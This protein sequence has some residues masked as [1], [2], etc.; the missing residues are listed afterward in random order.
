MRQ[1]E[2]ALYDYLF[3][4]RSDSLVLTGGCTLCCEQGLGFIG[5]EVVWGNGSR[6]SK[7][8]LVGKDS[9]GARPKETR[10]RG[11][12]CTGIPL[13]NKKTGAK[14]RIFLQKANVDPFSVFITNTVKCNVG[15]ECGLAYAKLVPV[16]IQHLRQEIYIVRPK[17][18]IALG[19][20]AA[21]HI[22]QLLRDHKTFSIT[23]LDE[24]VL[25]RGYPPY[26]STISEGANQ[27]D[28][29]SAIEVFSMLHPSFV[30]GR[31]EQAYVTNLEV[32]MSHLI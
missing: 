28:Q 23:G 11:S 32:I 6:T 14:L 20:D 25:L 13:T 17:I 15:Y 3:P 8:M 30:E 2:Y 22:Y 24:A 21:K 26:R 19:A 9:A 31:R 18:L 27:S 16:C 12:K 10:W 29:D 4:R 7:L 1:E 5:R